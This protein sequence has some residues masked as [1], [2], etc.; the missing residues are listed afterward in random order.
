MIDGAT[1]TF[2]K[3]I[4]GLSGKIFIPGLIASLLVEFSDFYHENWPDISFIVIYAVFAFLGLVGA[5]M[6][7]TAL[8]ACMIYFKFSHK[9]PSYIGLMIMP[10]GFIGVFPD[11]FP[12]YT[13]PYSSVTGVAILAWSFFL[14]NNDVFEYLHPE[15]KDN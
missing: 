10:L 12:A 3:A 15:L 2:A 4:D 13:I 5:Y 11:H 14:I 7:L 6:I 9:F 8:M 1:T